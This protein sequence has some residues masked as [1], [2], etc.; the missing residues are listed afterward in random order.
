MKNI[1]QKKRVDPEVK[2][3]KAPEVEKAIKV[4][5]SETPIM[6]KIFQKQEQTPKRLSDKESDMEKKEAVLPF[7]IAHNKLLIEASV[8]SGTLNKSVHEYTQNQ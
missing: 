7:T 8:K 3:D 4:S 6:K 5:T 1:L 2:S